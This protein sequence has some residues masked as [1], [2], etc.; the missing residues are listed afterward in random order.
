MAQKANQS[1]NDEQSLDVVY[2][3]K[4][5]EEQ[6]EKLILELESGERICILKSDNMRMSVATSDYEI[7]YYDATEVDEDE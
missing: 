4:D 6:K 1:E 3:C 2:E 7:D 5:T